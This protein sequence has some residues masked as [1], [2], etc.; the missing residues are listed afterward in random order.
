MGCKAK[1]CLVKTGDVRFFNASDEDAIFTLLN[2]VFGYRPCEVNSVPVAIDAAGW[3][4]LASVG[5]KYE[6][7]EFV[8]EII[9]ED[10]V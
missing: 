10:E 4:V 5:S 2:E 1:I 8:I 9:D 6:D 3:C 7:S